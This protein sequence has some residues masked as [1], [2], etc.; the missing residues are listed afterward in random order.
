MSEIIHKICYLGYRVVSVGDLQ[1][2]IETVSGIRVSGTDFSNFLDS[3][4]AVHKRPQGNAFGGPLSLPV[5]IQLSSVK[6]SRASSSRRIRAIVTRD[7][8]ISSRSSSRLRG[9][10]SS[11]SNTATRFSEFAR[12]A[13]SSSAVS[14][15]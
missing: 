14:I 4:I 12:K 1:L 9:L 15:A 10:S 6:H 13:I 7:A 5:S 3:M 11:V 2:P 8:S